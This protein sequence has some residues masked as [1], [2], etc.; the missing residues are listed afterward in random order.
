[1]SSTLHEKQGLNNY[2]VLVK[3]PAWTDVEVRCPWL[4][5]QRF[6]CGGC[7]F[8]YFTVESS[9]KHDDQCPSCKRRVIVRF[10]YQGN[11]V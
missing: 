4:G 7:K 6:K 3:G 9:I 11:P 5:L 8:G 10:D 2:I 1:M